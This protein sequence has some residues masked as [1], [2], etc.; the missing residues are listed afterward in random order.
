MRDLAAD[1]L[2]QLLARLLAGDADQLDQAEKVSIQRSG[3]LRS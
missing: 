3:P 2:G 1:A